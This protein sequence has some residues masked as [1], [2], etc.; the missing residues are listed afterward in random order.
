MKLEPA[1]ITKKEK[2][3]FMW[4]LFLAYGSVTLE[5]KFTWQK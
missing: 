3:G 5:E 4:G 2:N 1:A